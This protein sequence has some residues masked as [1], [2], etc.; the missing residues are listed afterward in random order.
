MANDRNEEERLQQQNAPTGGNDN[1]MGSQESFGQSDR[2]GSASMAQQGAGSDDYLQ[3][4]I[5]QGDLAQQDS[6]TQQNDDG[7]GEAAS[8]DENS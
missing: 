3:E 2:A 8:E 5:G 4:N 1:S 6:V 7:M